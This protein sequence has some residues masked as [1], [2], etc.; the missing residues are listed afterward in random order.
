MNMSS[1]QKWE[2][3]KRE[4]ERR[5]KKAL[6]DASQAGV[7]VAPPEAPKDPSQSGL[8]GIPEGG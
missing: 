6:A 7:D 4:R 3:G 5:L 2:P 1:L 8:T